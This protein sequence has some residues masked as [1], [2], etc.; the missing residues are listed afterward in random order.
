MV[1]HYWDHTLQ[2]GDD[3]H[4]SMDFILF[5]QII[6]R[7]LFEQSVNFTFLFALRVAIKP[8]KILN[9][10]KSSQGQHSVSEVLHDLANQLTV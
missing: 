7:S 1:A 5:S 3:P 4:K 2:N 9:T 10:M 8:S 6:L